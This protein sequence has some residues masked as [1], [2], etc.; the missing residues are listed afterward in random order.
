MGELLFYVFLLI[1][2]LIFVYAGRSPD[3]LMLVRN[4]R[5]LL[6]TNRATADINS[7]EEYAFLPTY[8]NQFSCHDVFSHC[9]IIAF[10]YVDFTNT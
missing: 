1:P 8:S 10:M 6:E 7:P 3:D 9:L 4:M 5:C 2:L